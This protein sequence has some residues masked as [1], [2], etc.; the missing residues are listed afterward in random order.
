MEGPIDPINKWAILTCEDAFL[1]S[2]LQFYITLQ[3]KIPCRVTV[4]SHLFKEILWLLLTLIQV[5]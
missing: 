2:F 5:Q 4:F 1:V 3:A